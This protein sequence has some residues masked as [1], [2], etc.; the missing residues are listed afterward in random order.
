M[1]GKTLGLLSGVLV[2]GIVLGTMAD[3]RDVHAQRAGESDSRRQAGDGVIA[4]DGP[5]VN[6]QQLIV[7]IDDRQQTMSSYFVDEKSGQISLR[8]V[9]NFRWDMQMSEF[10]GS[11]PSPE[12]IQ[13]LLRS[14]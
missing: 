5:L 6:G 9:R 3:H 13:A 8:C 7:L 2:T 11:E 10:N 4:I 14:R 1:R 12:K